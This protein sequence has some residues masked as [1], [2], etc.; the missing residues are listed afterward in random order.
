MLPTIDN[1]FILDT[2]R[3]YVF[4]DEARVQCNRGFKLDGSSTIRCGANQ[5]FEN[6]PTCKVCVR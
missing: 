4:S 6:L 5:T 2:R 3:R 1:G